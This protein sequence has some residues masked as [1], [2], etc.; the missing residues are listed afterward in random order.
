MAE[1]VTLGGSGSL[2][3]GEDKSLI[4]ELILKSSATTAVDMTGWAMVFDVRNRDASPEPPIVSHTP[5]LTGVFNSVRSSNTQRANVTLSDDDL[6]LFRAK[7]YRW[8]WKRLDAG[9]E[10]VLAYGDFA[11]QKA[12]AP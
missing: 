12:T 10:T 1:N 7:T 4:L 5:I 2:F 6:N 8:S 9:S 3:V 11:P